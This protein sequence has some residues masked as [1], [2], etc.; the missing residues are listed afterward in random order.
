MDDA[1]R[2][3]AEESLRE[4]ERNMSPLELMLHVQI[5]IFYTFVILGKIYELI[6]RYDQDDDNL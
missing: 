3:A 2:K 5:S 1:E 4:M 6:H